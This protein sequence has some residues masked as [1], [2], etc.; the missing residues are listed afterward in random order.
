MAVI[1]ESHPSTPRSQNKAGH[2]PEVD[3]LQ[4]K[5]R[6][7]RLLEWSTS[8]KHLFV[9]CHSYSSYGEQVNVVRSVET[10]EVSLPRPLCQ[11]GVARELQELEIRYYELRQVN[12]KQNK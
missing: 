5:H 12:M 4:G 10:H 9:N 1:S 2:S 7:K 3:Q 6:H 8:R 11:L